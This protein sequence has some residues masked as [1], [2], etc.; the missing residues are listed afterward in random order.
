[1]SAL[2]QPAIP[3]GSTVLI[4]GVNGFIASHIA[5]QFLKLGYKVRGTTR[6]TERNAWISKVFDSKYG[7]GQFELVSVPDMRADG[8][9]DEVVKGVSAFVHTATEV[10]FSPNPHVVVPAAVAGTTNALLAAAKEPSVKRFVLTSSSSSALIPKPNEY[11]KV[12]VDT[13]NDEA[14]AYAY[15]DPPYEAERGYPVYAA[16]KTLAEREA[17]KFVNE[18][19]PGF[20]LNTVLPNICFG[21][22]ID[23]KNQGHTSTSGML[24]ALFNGDSS[25]LASL[26]AQYYVDVQDAALLHVAAAIHPGAESER[27]FAF[28]EPVNGD[29]LLE[30]FHKLYPGRKFPENFQSDKD[31]SEIVPIKRAESLLRDLG[32]DGFTSLE[33]SVK[34]NTE[35][36]A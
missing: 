32:K 17:W 25:I 6:N 1:M 4:T 19:K 30:I 9:Y 27:I 11:R 22:T 26:P 24:A 2:E 10:S 33:T 14:V 8:A 36:I 7:P 16:S 21:A 18:K 20:T 23:L 28:A 12:T 3:K 31:L 13:W 29:G 34:R 35:D 5:D 15:R